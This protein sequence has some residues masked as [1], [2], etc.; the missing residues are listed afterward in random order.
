MAG[1]AAGSVVIMDMRVI[2]ILV[3]GRSVVM[4][5][6]CMVLMGLLWGMSRDERLSGMECD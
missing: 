6:G 1:R 5:R 2:G 4:G 3:I